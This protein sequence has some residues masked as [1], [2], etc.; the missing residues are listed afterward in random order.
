M[1]NESNPVNPS[2]DKSLIEKNIN[3][4]WRVPTASEAELIKAWTRKTIRDDRPSHIL[5]VLT[6]CPLILLLILPY[7]EHKSMGI[8]YYV[9]FLVF[10][11]GVTVLGDYCI[12]L[13][14][15]NNKKIFSGD[16]QI[17]NAVVVSTGSSRGYRYNTKASLYLNAKTPSGE[18]ISVGVNRLVYIVSYKNTPGFLV[19]FKGENPIKKDSKKLIKI[20]LTEKRFI[21]AITWEEYVEK[22]GY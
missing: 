19:R 11:A 21:P 17:T 3:R 16:Y 14:L 7:I 5:L 1:N 2:T 10:F 12:F 4:D 15:Q 22:R 8:G 18:I 20:D 13:I 6:N 9:F